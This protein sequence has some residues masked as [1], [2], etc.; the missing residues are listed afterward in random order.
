MWF[1]LKQRQKSILRLGIR[2][3]LHDP[4][5]KISVHKDKKGTEEIKNSS[6][7]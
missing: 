1:N 4:G 5:R 2:A 6:V 7:T 3:F